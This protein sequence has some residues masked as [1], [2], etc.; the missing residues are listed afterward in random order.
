MEYDL[1]AAAHAAQ[2]SGWTIVDPVAVE[3]YLAGGD[4]EQ[5]Q[6]G[7]ADRRL[8]AAGLADERQGL[9]TRDLEGHAVH[10]IDK[11]PAAEHAAA[12]RKMLLEVVDLEQRGTHAATA[13]FDA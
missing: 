1:H 12:D 5:S 3:H 10:G 2:A 4:V 7:G 6:D 13:A 9:A 11:G 8:A